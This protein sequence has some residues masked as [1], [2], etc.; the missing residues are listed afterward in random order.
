MNYCTGSRV[1]V[2]HNATEP[3]TLSTR[4]KITYKTESPGNTIHPSQFVSTLY[5]FF[6]LFFLLFNPIFCII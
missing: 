2:K 4:L 1:S 6:D 3:Y 5:P